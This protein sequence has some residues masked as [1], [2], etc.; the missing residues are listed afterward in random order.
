MCAVPCDDLASDPGCSPF[1]RSLLSN[2]STTLS[3]IK[4]LL[5]MNS[6]LSKIYHITSNWWCVNNRVRKPYIYKQNLFSWTN[7]ETH[8]IKLNKTHKRK[9]I[10]WDLSLFIHRKMPNMLFH[11]AAWHL[12]SPGFGHELKLLPVCSF[13]CSLGGIALNTLVSSYLFEAWWWV[14]WVI[15]I[16]PK[17]RICMWCPII[18]RMCSGYTWINE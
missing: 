18:P 4:Q 10:R 8:D 12:Q 16:A 2:S 6:L 5:K 13:A 7:R 1:S 3:R 14:R 9:E 11:V 17:W 15:W